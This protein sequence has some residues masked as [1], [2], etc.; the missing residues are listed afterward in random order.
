MP[1]LQDFCPSLKETSEESGVYSLWAVDSI[2]RLWLPCGRHGCLRGSH[3]SQIQEILGLRKGLGVGGQAAGSHGLE[4][5]QMQLLYWDSGENLLPTGLAYRSSPSMLLSGSII[6]K[7]QPGEL[8][9]LTT[10]EVPQSGWC[11]QEGEKN[12][13]TGSMGPLRSGKKV[14]MWLKPRDVP[15]PCSVY[16]RVWPN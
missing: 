13:P 10:P 1:T 6:L 15:V 5:W 11:E 14:K 7:R 16:H 12:L 3:S 8:P 2:Q 4:G 9:L